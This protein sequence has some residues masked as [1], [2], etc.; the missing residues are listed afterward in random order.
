[1]LKI[2]LARHGQDEDNEAG[3]LNGRRDKKLTALGEKQAESLA[4]QIKDNN[5]SFSFVYSS[6]LERARRTAKII[7]ERLDLGEP[8]IL[9]GLIERDF[10]VLAGKK[11]KDFLSE[12]K[13]EIIKSDQVDYFL[14]IEG[15]ETFPDLILRGQEIL[16]IISERHQDGSILLVTHGDIG[17]MIYAAYYKLDWPVVLTQFHFGNSDL[18]ILAPESKSEEAYVFKTKQFNT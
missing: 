16:R 7:C 5:L 15:A 2:Y 3:L 9:P 18:L 1:M 10:G 6:P 8:Q 4:R 17:K 14:N 11:I 12:Y 13:G